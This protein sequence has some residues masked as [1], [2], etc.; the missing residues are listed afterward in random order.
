MLV[1]RKVGS[2]AD[3]VVDHVGN[4]FLLNSLVPGEGS[5]AALARQ[6]EGVLQMAEP[7]QSSS[8][9]SVGGFP[10]NYVPTEIPPETVPGPRA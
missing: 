2:P 7:L 5:G 3:R 9:R 1:D 8:N 4:V 6:S 10:R